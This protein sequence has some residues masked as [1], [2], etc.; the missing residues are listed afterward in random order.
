MVDGGVELLSTGPPVNRVLQEIAFS[1]RGCL[2]P[3]VPVVGS[4]AGD[5]DLK[6][7]LAHMLWHLHTV[8]W[9]LPVGKSE[10]MLCLSEV[11]IL[12]PLG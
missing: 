10:T 5:R 12:R 8:T 9:L 1:E 6:W 11:D 3:L 7:W 2:P 4:A